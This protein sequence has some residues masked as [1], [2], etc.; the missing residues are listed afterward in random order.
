MLD[1]L[2]RQ[3]EKVEDEEEEDDERQ[4]IA[5]WVRGQNDFD[6]VEEDVVQDRTIILSDSKHHVDAT[7]KKEAI[8]E[9]YR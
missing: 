5:Q 1:E 2:I 3:V 9:F 6:G 4:N 7:V 8:E